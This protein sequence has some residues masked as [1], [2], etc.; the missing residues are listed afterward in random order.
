MPG[1]VTFEFDR[2]GP[3]QVVTITATADSGD[4]SFP[5]TAIPVG[6]SGRIVA[7]EVN[8]DAVGPTNLYDL[9]LPNE[10]GIDILQGL[11]ANLLI[12]TT[13]RKAVVLSGTEIHPAVAKTNTLTVTLVNN[14]VNSGK[15]V[16]K[17]YIEG[18]I[19]PT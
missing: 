17:L 10:N 5:A 6:I 18:V 9:T 4:A 14:S 1:T 11:G 12:A 19:N 7:L 15:T 3:I 16:I 2:Q 13:E 8:P